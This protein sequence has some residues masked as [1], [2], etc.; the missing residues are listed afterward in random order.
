[1]PYLQPA[2]ANYFGFIP[3]MGSNGSIRVTNYLVSSSCAAITI[4][5]AVAL[6]TRGDFVQPYLASSAPLIGI[7]ANTV[8]AGDGSTAAG[9]RFASTQTCL[10]YDDPAALFVGC[11]TTSG[12]IGTSLNN[13]LHIQILATGAVGSTG[14]GAAGR[15]IQALSGVTASSGVTLLPFTLVG[16][17]PI[18]TAYSTAAAGTASPQAEVRK[19][20]VQPYHH[21]FALKTTS[22]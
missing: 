17:H 20:M 8:S 5:D 12:V 2:T 3:A 18:E 21:A 22:T 7:A 1:M 16:M 14:V 9:I 4:G 11:D 15:S 6:S 13:G 10:V 19:F